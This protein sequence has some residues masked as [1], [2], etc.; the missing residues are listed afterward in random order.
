MTKPVLRTSLLA[1]MVVSCLTSCMRAPVVDL[2]RVRVGGIGFSGATLIAELEV[3]NPN[4]FAIETDSITFEMAAQDP[5]SRGN[6]T[7]VTAGTNAQRIRV[8][9]HAS[10]S[11]ELPIELAYA[12]LST[13]IRSIIQ[14]GRFNYRLSG[15]VFVRRPLP[16]RIPFTETGSI[17]V[18]G[19]R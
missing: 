1:A 17:S 8:E 14:N 11:V 15:Q 4:R 2:T 6:W 19:D 18:F 12:A 5:T 3:E 7:P 9:S 16:K 10:T 13:P